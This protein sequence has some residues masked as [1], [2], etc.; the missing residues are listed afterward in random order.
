MSF[1]FN[2]WSKWSVLIRWRCQNQ[3]KVM[4]LNFKLSAVEFADVKRLNNVHFVSSLSL[5][6][7][8]WHLK[9]PAPHGLAFT[10]YFWWSV[11]GAALLFWSE[12]EC[13]FFFLCYVFAYI[14]ELIFTPEI[15]SL[16]V[17]LL[18]CANEGVTY[19]QGLR[20]LTLVRKW[21]CNYSWDALSKL[22]D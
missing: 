14:N 8:Q 22:P 11:C 7:H 10:I 2:Y 19:C 16:L 6:I 18:K 9:P 1:C 13:I 21:S 12:L 15:I 3:L 20:W 4:P 5:F 17:T